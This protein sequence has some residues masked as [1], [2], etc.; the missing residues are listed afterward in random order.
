MKTS[1]NAVKSEDS[2]SVCDGERELL[3]E[4]KEVCKVTC[5]K[6]LLW[7]IVAQ[8]GTNILFFLYIRIRC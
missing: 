4:M 3:F 6:I 2:K 1:K 5:V 8:K 7:S